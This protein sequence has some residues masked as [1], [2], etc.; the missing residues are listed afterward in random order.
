MDDLDA[1]RDEIKARIAVIDTELTLVTNANGK[2]AAQQNK[3]FAT[4]CTVVSNLLHEE[5]KHVLAQL[6]SLE[7]YLRNKRQYEELQELEKSVDAIWKRYKD[8]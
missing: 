3:D 8:R 6:E 4:K 2:A 5:R 1:Q 7:N